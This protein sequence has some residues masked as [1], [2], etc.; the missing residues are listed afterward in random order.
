L[1]CTV[2]HNKTSALQQCCTWNLCRAGDSWKLTVPAD[3]QML[4]YRHMIYL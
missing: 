4:S 2:R 1:S 3:R